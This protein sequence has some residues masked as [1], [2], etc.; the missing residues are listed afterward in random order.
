VPKDIGLQQLDIRE[1]AGARATVNV[2]L[3]APG[4]MYGDRL[5]Q[6]DLRLSKT[7]SLGKGRK[8][9]A[10]VDGYNM[11]NA[12]PGVAVNTTYGP[13]WLQPTTILEGRFFKVGGRFNF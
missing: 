13:Q 4:S 7:F 11:F 3:I 9:Q 1:S 12:N 10:M 2:N 5:N 8:L 6:L